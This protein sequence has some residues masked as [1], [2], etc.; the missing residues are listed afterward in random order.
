MDYNVNNFYSGGVIKNVMFTNYSNSINENS[1]QCI[2]QLGKKVTIH[3]KSINYKSQRIAN[4][5]ANAITIKPYGLGSSM[6]SGTI[7]PYAD[8]YQIVV[9]FTPFIIQCIFQLFI[10]H[11]K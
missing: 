5:D 9:H 8:I 2:M 3:L 4:A 7:I 6:S 1:C 10:L 11:M